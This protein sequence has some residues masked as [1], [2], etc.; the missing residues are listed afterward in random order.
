MKYDFN[1]NVN[2][3]TS[4]AFLANQVPE[5][6]KVLEFGTANG[7]LTKYLTENKNCAVYGVEL[8]ESDA[9]IARQY[10]RN[11]VVCDI[12]KFDWLNEYSNYAF[13]CI[14]FGDVLEHLH[15]PDT[16]LEK[17]KELLS[18]SGKILIS[19]PNISNNAVIMELLENKFNYSDTGLLDSTHIKFFTKESLEKL[20]V[21]SGLFIELYTAIHREPQV[22]EFNQNYERFPFEV[23]EYLQSRQYSTVYQFLVVA[24]KEI[25]EKVEC[26]NLFYTSEVYFDFGDGFNE[27]E[28]I[29]TPYGDDKCEFYFRNL[30]DLISDKKIRRIR[31]DICDS[32]VVVNKP[33]ITVNEEKI[34]SFT[35]NGI[36]SS[37]E[38]LFDHNDPFIIIDVSNFD[39]VSTISISFDSITHIKSKGSLIT[40]DEMEYKE[41]CHSVESL[42]LK[43][44]ETEKELEYTKAFANSLGLKNRAKRLVRKILSRFIPDKYIRI[45]TIAA[46]NPK[47]VGM[48][49]YD[50]KSMNF[51][52]IKKRIS[53]GLAKGDQLSSLKDMFD[54]SNELGWFES[55]EKNECIKIN[56]ID[57][58]IPVY[59]GY[60]YLSPLLKA[61][62]ENTTI[63]YRLIIVEDCSSDE[64]IKPFIS[65]FIENN[66]DI[67]MF[68]I[69]NDINLGFV[70]SVNK[71]VKETKD[72]FVILNTDVEVPYGWAERLMYPIFSNENIASTTPFTNSGTICSFPNWLED[73]ELFN[74]LSLAQIDQAFSKV[75]ISHREISLPTGV[76]FCMGINRKVVEK[77]GFFDELQ[78][79]KGYG[80]ENDWCCRAHKEGYKSVLVPNLFV[81]HKH[82][83]SFSSVQK[84]ELQKKNM[85]VLQK[86]HPEYTLDVATH[87]SENPAKYLRELIELVLVCKEGNSIPSLVINH[88]LGGGADE[89]IKNKFG[90]DSKLF[91]LSY[92]P[93]DRKY[94]LEFM[95]KNI[96]KSYS[97]NDISLLKKVVYIFK[98]KDIYINQF[99]SFPNVEESV[100]NIANLVKEYELNSTFF[101]HDYFSVCPSFNLL[102]SR[103]AFCNVPSDENVCNR[104]LKNNRFVTI[105]SESF[106]SYKT[107]IN[108]RDW[109]ATW[110]CLLNVSNI[111][112]FSKS[113]EEIIKRAFFNIDDN[114]IKVIPHSVSWFSHSD[115]VQ[116]PRREKVKIAVVG[117]LTIHKGINQ[118][119]KLCC[120]IDQ[121]R[122][123]IEVVVFGDVIDEFPALN[124][125][126]K[127]LGEYRKQELP[128]LLKKESIDIAFVP[129]ICPETFSYTTE[130][131]I[132]LGIPVMVYNLGA[133]AERVKNYEKG[134]LINTFDIESTIEA[135]EKLSMRKFE[136]NL[137]PKSTVAK[138]HCVVNDFYTF[139]STVES[140]R[141]MIQYDVSYSDNTSENIGIPKRY[142]DFIEKN[143]NSDCWL[144]LCHQD[145]TFL[146]NMDDKFEKMDKNVL[147]GP[148]GATRLKGKRIILGQINQ[149]DRG[150]IFKHGAKIVHE[151][152]VDTVDCMCIIVHSSL[153]K[154]TGLRFDE[155]LDFH[156]YTEEFCLSGFLNHNLETKAIQ[157][158]CLHT[159]YGS[160]SS[161]YYKAVRY[162]KNKYSGYEY[163][164][165]CP[166]EEPIV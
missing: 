120:F 66:P 14:V 140:S 75:N 76:G 38:I 88:R 136:F 141:F 51:T 113:S 151:R 138:I 25:V 65:D 2:T 105:G 74:G 16:V 139:E 146:E 96:C 1:L 71:A 104:C 35:H 109:R 103:L 30:K 122:L 87:I 27:V 80:E 137:S 154:R 98:I 45:L 163:E 118:I 133:P 37:Y 42:T 26:F 143:I 13:D 4:Q 131:I 160:L 36:E 115:Y 97:I 32:K 84:A 57:I 28:K 56:K 12:E 153:L 17:A 81:Y 43:N 112:C 19:I 79:G 157:M 161:S 95:Y 100:R 114:R 91:F 156:H 101:V 72:H 93:F 77:I 67:S 82:G 63:P 165:T 150:R 92:D 69:E 20:I 121:Y 162:V 60:E 8:N 48:I 3:T 158:E 111:V 145:F 128:T 11:I 148:I 135:I 166:L 89:F 107:D 64:R 132:T 5:N 155:K 127:L 106:D 83:G 144:V 110:A 33:Q 53:L 21:D 15:R 9:K 23:S 129:S 73:N 10:A 108:I 70:L 54:I 130:E 85:Q 123:P 68:Y 126:I 58:I 102:D 18:P 41:L 117:H 52:S 49:L 34:D 31:F 78:F 149:G 164:S 59:N 159:S 86:L 142:N 44:N 119:R 62:K 7:K 46:K 134:F 90:Q 39:H 50:I 6:S 125:K 152:V 94:I 124:L 55:I 61:I 99:V 116:P 24:R 47:V 147:Y 22:T 40:I 29:S